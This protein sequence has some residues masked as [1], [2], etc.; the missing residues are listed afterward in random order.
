MNLIAVLNAQIH[1]NIALITNGDRWQITVLPYFAEYPR[2]S[3]LASP[4]S[5]M[6][7]SLKQ[8]R[9]AVTGWLGMMNNR[10]KQL[11][12]YIVECTLTDK[13]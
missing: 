13:S 2:L 11:L 4:Q 7:C 6:G 3:H 9:S 8:I 1:L 10:T 5:F 12:L